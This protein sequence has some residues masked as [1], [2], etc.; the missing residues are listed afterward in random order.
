MLVTCLAWRNAAS[1]TGSQGAEGG[2]K[3]EACSRRR[4]IRCTAK[5]LHVRAA[6]LHTAFLPPS[7]WPVPCLQEEAAA[8]RLQEVGQGSSRNAGELMLPV[9]CAVLRALVDSEVPLQ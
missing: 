6:P 4:S 2:N 5:S 7:H 8:S 9:R 1:S 3:E